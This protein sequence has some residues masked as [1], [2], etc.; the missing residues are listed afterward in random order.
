[1]DELFAHSLLEHID[2]KLRA[3]SS[4]SLAPRSEFL[5]ALL[6]L[7]LLVSDLIALERMDAIGTVDDKPSGPRRR[8][9]SRTG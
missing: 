2:E 6:E 8:I 4:R 9:R 5:D 1:M 3:G 7:R